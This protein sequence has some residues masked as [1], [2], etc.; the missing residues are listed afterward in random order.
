LRIRIIGTG[1]SG[2]QSIPI[3]AT[4]A[5]HLY[6]VQRTTNFSLPARDAPMDPVKEPSHKAHHPER[7]RSA[8]DTPFGIAGYPPPTALD[9]TEKERLRAYEAKWA[10]GGSISYIY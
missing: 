3:I 10:E 6:V 2:V 7:R 1:S 5:K 8:F 9:A 4:Q